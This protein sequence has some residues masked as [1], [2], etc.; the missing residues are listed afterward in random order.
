M[1]RLILLLAL[2]PSLAGAVPIDTAPTAVEARLASLFGSGTSPQAAPGKL[3]R[4]RLQASG[5]LDGDGRNDWAG[6]V[7]ARDDHNG[8]R[9]YVLRNEGQDYALAGVSAELLSDCDSPSC[10]IDR[11]DIAGQRLIIGSWSNA[12]GCIDRDVHQFRRIDSQWRLS[13]SHFSRRERLA[14][15]RLRQLEIEHDTLNGRLTL[16]DQQAEQTI[17]QRLRQPSQ[18]LLLEDYTGRPGLSLPRTTALEQRLR[19]GNCPLP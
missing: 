9:L 12:H 19:Q 17:R 7:R 16:I 8:Q 1:P 15:S 4:V 11:L 10:D 5:D 3:Y 14:G 18:P 6:L 2:L 13:A